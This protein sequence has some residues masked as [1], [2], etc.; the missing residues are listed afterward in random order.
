[1]IS[2]MSNMEEETKRREEEKKDTKKKD[3]K[4]ES[5]PMDRSIKVVLALVIILILIFSISYGVKYYKNK[6]AYEA[7]HKEYNYFTFDKEGLHWKTTWVRGEQQYILRLRHWPGELEDIKVTGKLNQIFNNS[8]DIYLTF[9]PE[10]EEFSYMALAATELSLNIN[11]ALARNMIGACLTNTT[12]DC[13]NR[14]IVT[15]ED[16]DKA[17]IYLKE[18]ENPKVILSGNC[19]IIEGSKEGIVQ[20]AERILYTWYGIMRV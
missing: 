4:D 9:N 2:G 13:Y 6:K 18:A 10:G 1:M 17:V 15:C 8:L 12:A 20:A 16:K 14:P 19:M 7:V 5:K 11:K 3:K